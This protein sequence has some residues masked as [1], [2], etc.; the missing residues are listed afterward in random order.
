LTGLF[1]KRM[2]KAPTEPNTETKG[3]AGASSSQR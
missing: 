2:G 1:R 3:G